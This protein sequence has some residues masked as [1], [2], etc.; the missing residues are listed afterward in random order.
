MEIRPGIH[1]IDTDVGGRSACVF[2]IQGR[3]QAV[4][5]DTGM[6]YAPAADI[7]PYIDR[8]GLDRNL[9]RHVIISHSDFDHMGGGAALRAA[10]P[11]AQFLCHPAE[12]TEAQDLE[13]LISHRLGEFGRDHGMPD[14]DQTLDW[15]R[16]NAAPTSI[17]GSLVGGETLNL[18][19]LKVGVLLT[20]GH[21]AGHLSLYIAEQKVA[22][23]ADAVLG[24]SLLY[25]DGRPAFPPTYRY[26]EAY[27][28]T[29][30][31]LRAMKIDL[32]LTSHFVPM[33]GGAVLAFLIQTE[34]FMNRVEDAV[35]D[36]LRDK[37][38]TLRDLATS[39]APEFGPWPTAEGLLMCWPI[40]GHLE[41]MVAQGR[42]VVSNNGA[43]RIYQ[44]AEGG[45]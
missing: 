11:R 24:E 29:I 33:E 17:D 7:L 6:S 3:N 28:Q 1:R 37:P 8:I 21:S 13:M 41:R 12:K 23:V 39:M 15:L 14:S 44:L 43:V 32:M 18:G 26:P 31:R 34:G 20:P 42:V 2:L 5:F 36:R 16:S 22:I 40:L 45:L 25:R 9:V 4:L 19:D 35:A 38:Q 27:S 10:L 30:R